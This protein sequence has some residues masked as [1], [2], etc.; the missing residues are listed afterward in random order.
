[1]G[2][3]DSDKPDIFLSYAR[4][5]DIPVVGQEA[6][7]V[8][9]F[10]LNLMAKLPM[11]L[12][13]RDP[14]DVWMDH[15]LPGNVEFP[16]ELE[17]KVRDSAVFLIVLSPQYR[18]SIW[19]R[20][21]RTWFHDEIK[22]RCDG[23]SR[24][25]VVEIE[26][27]PRP[28]ELKFLTGYRFWTKDPNSGHTTI[29]G[30]PRANPD[31]PSHQP[32]YNKIG[33]L[34]HDLA[35]TITRLK[36]NPE[37]T[38]PEA[39]ATVYLAEVTDDLDE[40]REEVKRYLVDARLRVL[41]ETIYPRDRTADYQSAVER[42]LEQSVVFIQLLNKTPGRRL[43]DSPKSFVSLQHDF[44]TQRGLSILQWRASGLDLDA[45]TNS[46]HKRLLQGPT[47]APLG[48]QE[49]MSRIVERVRELMA[50]PPERPTS[51][52]TS[53]KLVFVDAQETNF[54]KL[55][56]LSI[57]MELEKRAIRVMIS[58]RGGRP[59]AN[60]KAL[61]AG[62]RYC[63]ALIFVDGSNPDWLVAEV[64][65]YYK[66]RSECASPARPIVQFVVRPAPAEDGVQPPRPGF[67]PEPPADRDVCILEI[68]GIDLIDCAAPDCHELFERF[69]SAVKQ[70]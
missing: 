63:D 4:T 34:A 35:Q 39:R 56:A 44:A 67:C 55:V 30:Y 36:S 17:K 20:N 21:E 11:K 42:D 51:S 53:G 28:A 43:P 54:D 23:G 25:F 52:V 8:S 5:D 19:C 47:V 61:D 68:T 13:L 22:K 45:V 65:H 29:M 38:P 32:Y 64:Q 16:A 27:V 15:Q 6:G 50:P 58:E 18:S 37:P 1:M 46:D 3:I 59:G 9:T 40:R 41:P 7:W 12:E 24:V 10:R 70:P 60:R 33:D 2:L 57:K 49:F 31:D 66:I 48:L 14:L 69:I 62:L 26:E